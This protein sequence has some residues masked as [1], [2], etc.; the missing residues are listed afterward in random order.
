MVT[1]CSEWMPEEAE[2]RLHD[3]ESILQVGMKPT[4]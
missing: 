2:V 1:G 3:Y 4:G